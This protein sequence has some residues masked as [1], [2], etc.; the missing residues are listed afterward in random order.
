[1]SRAP[2]GCHAWDRDDGL[3]IGLGDSIDDLQT[4]GRWI[5]CAEPVE[6]RE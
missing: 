1:M 5:R 4:T 3:V 2:R 6:V